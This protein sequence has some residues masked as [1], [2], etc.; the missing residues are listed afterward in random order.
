MGGHLL[1]YGF[2]KTRGGKMKYYVVWAGGMEVY[3]DIDKIMAD[4]VAEGYI[5]SGYD[6]VQVKE[7]K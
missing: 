5:N 2:I 1:L 4:W 6:D 3:E 7:E